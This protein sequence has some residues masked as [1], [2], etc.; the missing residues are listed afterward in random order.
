MRDTIQRMISSGSLSAFSVSASN[1]AVG[2]PRAIQ[3]VQ[4]Q[5]SAPQQAAP[6]GAAGQTRPQPQ[7]SP[8]QIMPRGSLLDLSV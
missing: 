6:V 3:Q 7:A 2:G 8:G 1:G 5:R 4:A